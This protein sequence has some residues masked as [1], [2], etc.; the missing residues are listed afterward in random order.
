[1]N[2]DRAGLPLFYCPYQVIM[3]AA[4]KARIRY[5]MACDLASRYCVIPGVW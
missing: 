4:V 1:M 2:F 3:V 5:E